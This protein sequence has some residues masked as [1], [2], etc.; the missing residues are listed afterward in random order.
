MVQEILL[1][2]VDCRRSC[3]VAYVRLLA[4]KFDTNST[5]VVLVELHTNTYC[6]LWPGHR[7]WQDLGR[8]R[9]TS[10]RL[11]TDTR[12]SNFSGW[13]GREKRTSPTEKQT[14]VCLSVVRWKLLRI[15]FCTL[16]ECKTMELSVKILHRW[17]IIVGNYIPQ[18]KWDKFVQTSW[19]VTL[20][21]SRPK[22]SLR[23]EHAHDLCWQ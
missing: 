16:R 7:H 22:V 4:A 12:S 23:M 21:S 18:I 14:Y 20:R 11:V 13:T 1:A 9:C 10:K 6:R 8:L 3:W 5:S 15:S 17:I 2:P 19:W